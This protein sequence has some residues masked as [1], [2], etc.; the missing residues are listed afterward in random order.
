MGRFCFLYC[1][2]FSLLELN[3]TVKNYFHHM[4]T[5]YKK[6]T[7]AVWAGDENN[8]TNGATTT[9]IINSVTF[10]YKDLDEWYD[11]S[12]GNK[13]GYIY[14]RNTNPTVSALEEKICVL[15]NAEAATSFATGMAA[16]SNSNATINHVV[17]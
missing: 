17:L 7:E 8:N 11:V 9:P 16:I 2:D 13:P 5:S 12:K 1:F 6:G 15:E 10:A 4:N 3:I 14:S